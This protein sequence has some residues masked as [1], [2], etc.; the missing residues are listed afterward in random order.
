MGG[1]SD[2]KG[3]EDRWGVFVGEDVGQGAVQGLAE[4]VQ[5][6]QRAIRSTGLEAAQSGIRDTGTEGE[7]LEGQVPAAAAQEISQLTAQT[8]SHGP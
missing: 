5:V 1:W 3:L 2:R 4:L 7:L 8:R 6:I